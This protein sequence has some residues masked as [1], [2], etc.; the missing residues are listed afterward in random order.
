MSLTVRTN[1]TSLNAQRNL[2]NTTND[3]GRTFQR[4]S[5]GYRI[6]SARDDAAGLQISN[7]LTSQIGGLGVAVRNSN[8][9]ISLS[10][11]AEGA[12]QESTSILQ[13]I[14]N[15]A[16]Q[17]AN[18]IFS[19]SDRSALQQEVEQLK[20]ELDRIAETTRFGE[21]ALLDGTFGTASFQVGARSFEVVDV[22]IGAFFA[23]NMG[24]Q[25][26]NMQKTVIGAG[27][28]TTAVT[29][30][31][32][33]S[34]VSTTNIATGLGGIALASAITSG[35]VLGAATTTTDLLKAELSGPLG[36]ATL[37][38]GTSYSA[39]N[40]QQAIQLHTAR[41][42]VFADAR[43]LIA[44]DFF[45]T[46]GNSL[47]ATGTLNSLGGVLS[48]PITVQFEL[49]GE[50]TDITEDPPRITYTLTDTE[51]LSGLANA[52]NVQS[53]VTGISARVSLD[54]RLEM[55]SE[56]G[57]TIQLINF[58][59]DPT[60][61]VGVDAFNYTYSGPVTDTS[62]LVSWGNIG[63]SAATVDVNFIGTVRLNADDTVNINTV[64][65]SAAADVVS[66]AIF[67]TLSSGTELG[68]VLFDVADIDISTVIGAQ[69]SL[70][71]ADGAINFID[72]QRA[73]LGAVQN[74]LESTIANLSNIIENVSFSRSAIRDTDFA[75]ATAELAKQQILQ[76]AGTSVLSQ[77]N[78]LPQAALS[79]LG[80]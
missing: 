32:V 35:T 50:N 37:S 19:D 8:D 24:T 71:V 16:I 11:S 75:E 67:Q 30:S 52:I 31:E 66:N 14:R 40:V 4:L 5:S 2:N 45:T 48:S 22:A 51:D 7:R 55:T 63:V 72:R 65:S 34:I 77:A 44:L 15:L 70:S 46:S 58:K 41:T 17:S 23:E 47:N 12:L 42:G 64:E 36:E 53:S 13:R 74:R 49:R 18:G 60:G 20:R 10:Q 61:V 56:R 79:L 76:Q 59:T 9:A 73:R 69:L 26:I 43:T 21:R 57:D 29:T 78:Q 3:L 33:A 54:G 1:V 39:Y 62:Q 27:G 68:G 25:E 80:V 28:F 38:F 6:N